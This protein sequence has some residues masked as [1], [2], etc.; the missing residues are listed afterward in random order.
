MRPLRVIMTGF[1]PYL[2]RTEIDF[3]TFGKKGIYLVT[4]DTGAGKTTIFDAI[5]YALF[6]ELSGKDRTSKMVRSSFADLEDITEVELDFELND[7]KYNVIRNPAYFRKAVHSDK[8]VERLADATLTLPDGQKVSGTTNVNNKIIELLGINKD[9]FC[10]LAMIAQGAF[11]ELLFADTLKRRE[12]F[13][14]IFK[15]QKYQNIQDTLKEQ[16]RDIKNK[17]SD[18]QKLMIN[19]FNETMCDSN[20]VLSEKL[21]AE[22]KSLVNWEDKIDILE[23][24]ISADK[25]LIDKLEKE[26]KENQNKLASI[27]EKIGIINKIKQTKEE[28]QNNQ[29]ELEIEKSNFENVKET[30]KIKEKNEQEIKSAEKI[31]TSIEKD[32]DKYSELKN[33]N[34]NKILLDKK[35]QDS[36]IELEKLLKELVEDENQLAQYKLQFESVKKS[37]EEFEKENA[38]YLLLKEKLIQ[39]NNLSD[40]YNNTVKLKDEYSELQEKSRIAIENSEKSKRITLEKNSI[41]LKNMAGI[42]A[43]NLVENEPCPVCGSKD[44]PCV[45]VKETEVL[46]EEELNQLKEHD[47]ELEKISQ[48]LSQNAN[49]KKIEIQKNIENLEKNSKSFIEEFNFESLN[50][51]LIEKQKEFNLELKKLSEKLS[52]LQDDKELKSKIEE[53]I[54]EKEKSVKEKNAIIENLRITLEQLKNDYKHSSETIT[55]MFN[56]LEYKSKED[57][58]SKIVEQKE[59]IENLKNSSQKIQKEYDECNEK[60]INLNGTIQGLEK[61]LKDGEQIENS[62][63]IL[64]IKE[65]LDFEKEEISQESVNV[66]SRNNTNSKICEKLK[67]QNK[68]FVKTEKEYEM[69]KNLSDTANGMLLGKDKIMLETYVQ[70]YY[71]DRVVELANVRLMKMTDNRYELIRNES[72]EKKSKAGL[73]LDVIDHY[74][75]TQRSVKSLSGGETFQASLSLALGL[76]D[77][78]SQESGGIK[79]DS[80]FIDE[81]FGSLDSDSL[82]KAMSALI[83]L[84]ERDCLVGIISHVEA[85]KSRIDRQIVVTKTQTGKSEVNII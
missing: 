22:K 26:S 29:R 11:R 13:Q 57:A 5:T 63:E 49:N 14:K 17:L 3:T 41:Y 80:L 79:I 45:A 19:S 8:A 44:H 42:L 69:I 71:L 58:D 67:S 50:T 34:D 47:Q 53:K 73:E 85:L 76:S 36:Q 75:R 70:M 64:L 9:Q 55:K 21:E 16:E 68:E 52:K 43:E 12:I 77:E 83:N 78:V 72:A 32:L 40:D 84:T 35:I 33:E 27:N 4:G 15:T 61:T 31:I 6:D 23:H 65:K 38:V 54:P 51:S 56:E 1:G 81:G 60:I 66:I 2:N 37:G 39:I 82:E 48:N 30:L 25:K 62:E 20:E 10:Q 74:N 24:I 59:L 28:L 46:T 18:I 7:E